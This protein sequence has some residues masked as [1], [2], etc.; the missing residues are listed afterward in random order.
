MRNRAEFDTD[1]PQQFELKAARG[2]TRTV[3]AWPRGLNRSQ[4]PD[5]RRTLTVVRTPGRE[6]KTGQQS[7]RVGAADVIDH[8]NSGSA[9]TFEMKWSNRP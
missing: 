8:N 2:Q 3:I 6:F 7:E 1:P 9:E 4:V 5:G